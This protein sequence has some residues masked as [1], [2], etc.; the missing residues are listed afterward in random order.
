[1][2]AESIGFNKK[3]NRQKRPCF[4]HHSSVWQCPPLCF[5]LRVRTVGHFCSTKT[6]RNRLIRTKARLSASPFYFLTNGGKTSLSLKDIQCLCWLRVLSCDPACSGSFW[7]VMRSS[8]RL[9]DW[10]SS[11]ARQRS[12][13]VRNSFKWLILKKLASSFH[14][15]YSWH[16]SRLWK[17]RCETSS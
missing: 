16:C 5:R 12:S 17:I 4:V 6:H 9:D 11:A 14:I 1:M 10:Y 13:M 2:Y 15:K 3:K 7:T 8:K